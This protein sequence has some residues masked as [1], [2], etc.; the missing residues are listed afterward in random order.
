M[1]ML[2]VMLDLQLSLLD[3][4]QYFQRSSNRTEEQASVPFQIC[5]HIPAWDLNV[6]FLFLL[7][8]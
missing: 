8:F 6:V 1:L 2:V 5:R 7:S 3:V 4:A